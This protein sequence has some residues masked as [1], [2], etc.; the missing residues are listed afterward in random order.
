MYTSVLIAVVSLAL[1]WIAAFTLWWQMH[2]WRTPEVLASTRF[3]RPDGEGRLA[4]SLLLPARHE[5]AVLEHTIDRLLESSHTD[6]EII[7][8]VGHDDPG[9][10]AVAE[11][12]A[13]RRPDRVRVVVDHHEK[14]NKPKALNTAL[15]SCRGD[16]VGG[17][18]R[19]GDGD[20]PHQAPRATPPPQPHP[21]PGGGGGAGT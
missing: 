12:A 11:R 15:P 5:Q 4:F 3:D 7:V 18:G 10:A 1:F 14:K 6:Y 8:I 2:A 20:P 19:P 17:V 13:G 16:I 9:T 21:P